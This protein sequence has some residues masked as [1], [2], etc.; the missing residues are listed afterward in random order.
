MRKFV[1]DENLNGCFMNQEEVMRVIA[2][3]RNGNAES[4][5]SHDFINKFMVEFQESYEDMLRRYNGDARKTNS[6]IGLYLSNNAATLGITRGSKQDSFNVNYNVT[7]NQN[8]N[9]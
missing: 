5:D 8:W 9:V 7:S 6:A 3:F 4:F 1:G 2:G